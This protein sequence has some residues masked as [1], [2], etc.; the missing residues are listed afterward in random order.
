MLFNYGVPVVTEK[1]RRLIEENIER[2]TNYP[3]HIL[4]QNYL[5]QYYGHPGALLET[6][7]E[8]A[9]FYNPPSYGPPP[10]YKPVP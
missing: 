6:T 9:S 10:P 7:A 4:A 2:G 1:V 5:A 8:G 3:T